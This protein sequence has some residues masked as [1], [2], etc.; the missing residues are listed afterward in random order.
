MAKR[1]VATKLLRQGLT[2]DRIAEQMGVS[3][4]TMTRYMKLQVAEGD[5]KVSDVFFG[6][7]PDRRYVLEN[8][9]SANGDPAQPPSKAYYSAAAERGVSWDEANLYWSLRDS[10]LSR[11][12]MYEHLAD[13]EVELHAFIRRTLEG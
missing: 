12:D 4:Q 11:G 13:L 2:L 5:L 1:N 10:R 9:L 3:F 6:L 8:L 7:A